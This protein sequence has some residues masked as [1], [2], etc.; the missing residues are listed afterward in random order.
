[1]KKVIVILIIFSL[2]FI[3]FFTFKKD[4]E[5]ENENISII[6]E[7][8]EG[9]I[10]A[11][12]YPDKEYYE[13]SNINCKNTSDNIYVNFN[14]ETWKLNLS[15]EE[16]KVDGN[17]NCIVH[18]KQRNRLGTEVIT[19]KYKENNTEGLIKL[20]QPETEQTPA[21]VEYRYS[22][23]NEEVKNYV[24]FNNETWRIIGVSPV[25]DG[26]GNYENRLKIIREESI[27]DYSWDTSEITINNGWGVNQWGESGTY[28]G[29]DLMRLL[30]PGY[31]SESINNSLYW[32]R[33][34][35]TCYNGGGNVATSCDFSL[36]GLTSEA[37]SMIEDAKWYTAASEYDVLTQ[38][39]YN[40]ERKGTTTQF[41]DIGITVTR[42]PS[43][44]GKV[45]LMY[46]SDYGYASSGCREKE[47]IL[48]NYNNETCTSTNWL[49]NNNFKWILT[50]TTRTDSSVRVVYSEGN[51]YSFGASHAYGIHPATYLSTSVKI[52][53]GTGT[54]DNMYQLSL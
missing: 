49:Y 12:T 29:A 45:G 44:I 6:I 13:Y 21:L 43:W 2:M 14:K 42:T 35:G 51:V 27:G 52:T 39:S 41:T 53:S 16:E 15:V 20:N 5:K 31:E 19:S 11:S 7:T 23:S 38:E 28:N 1:M 47:Q 10:E 46:P 24:N 33:E 18:F 9:N 36:T 4:E 40:Q 8:N 3:S 34:S 26:T 37:K 17:F 48:Y 25:D 50:P 54:K 30:N 22:G 32:N